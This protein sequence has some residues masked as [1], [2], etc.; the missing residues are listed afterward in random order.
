MP[1][2]F[3]I[4]DKYVFVSKWVEPVSINMFRQVEYM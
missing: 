4:E 2:E 3:W 1:H